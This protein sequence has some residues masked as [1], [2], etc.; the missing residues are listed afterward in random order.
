MHLTGS[1]QLYNQYKI[2]SVHIC[3]YGTN[4]DN[5][6]LTTKRLLF[7]SHWNIDVI[8]SKDRQ[9]KDR[10]LHSLEA[11][12]MEAIKVVALVMS[13]LSLFSILTNFGLPFFFKVVEEKERAAI[14]CLV[15]LSR[16]VHKVRAYSSSW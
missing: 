1:A 10:D 15:R 7:N 6:E 11:E 3:M 8:I 16:E 14:F 4:I 5:K 13:I 9:P 2:S 12:P